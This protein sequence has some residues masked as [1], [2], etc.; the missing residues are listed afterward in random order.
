MFVHEYD[1]IHRTSCCLGAMAFLSDALF[2]SN[3][4]ISALRVALFSSKVAILEAAACNLSNSS[5]TFCETNKEE[6]GKIT[7]KIYSKKIEEKTM[8]EGCNRNASVR[9]C[10]STKR[11]FHARAN[12]KELDAYHM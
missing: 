9:W 4:S 11:L 6:Q 5:R 3:V 1:T 12:Q 10:R 7:R 8:R 2:A